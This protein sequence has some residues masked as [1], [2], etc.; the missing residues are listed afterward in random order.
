MN[1]DTPEGLNTFL[2]KVFASLIGQA[3]AIEAGPRKTAAVP[4]VAFS[5][6]E[7][8]RRDNIRTDGL[9]RTEDGMRPYSYRLHVGNIAIWNEDG[10][11]SIRLEHPDGTVKSGEFK[12]EGEELVIRLHKIDVEIDGNPP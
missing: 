11:T 4:L 8:Q 9:R 6:F 3:V 10:Q 2:G 7:G 12:L 5:P 1:E